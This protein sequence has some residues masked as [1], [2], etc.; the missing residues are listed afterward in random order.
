MID[1]DRVMPATWRTLERI[2]AAPVLLAACLR[3]VEED[4]VQLAGGASL[5]QRL[6]QEVMATTAGEAASV[7]WDFVAETLKRVSETHAFSPE[8]SSWTDSAES[9]FRD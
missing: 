2:I 8:A 6:A 3:L 7:Q 1:F 4:G 5:S 9:A